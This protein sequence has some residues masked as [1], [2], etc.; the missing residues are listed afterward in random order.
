MRVLPSAAVALCGALSIVCGLAACGGGGGASPPSPDAAA[1]EDGGAP[2][3]SS[4]TAITQGP[5]AGPGSGDTG[6][7]PVDS[8]GSL[9][10]SGSPLDSGSTGD[11]A[12]DASF[13]VGPHMSLTVPNSGGPVIAHPTLVTITFAGDAERSFA[14]TLGAYL[15]TSPWLS[16]VGPQYGVGLG[17]HVPVELTQTAPGTIDD[18][19]IQALIASLILEGLAPAPMGGSAI[20][21][22][23]GTPFD[24]VDSGPPADAGPVFGADGGGDA[25]PTAE[26][27]PAVYMIYIPTTT[28][29]TIDGSGLCDVSGGGYHGQAQGSFNGLTFAYAVVSQ[30]PMTSK[31][32]LEMAV[33]HEFIE[34]ATDPA[35]SDPAWS[36]Q[37]PNNVWSYFGGEVGDLC[38][39]V[40]PQWAEGAYA[41]LQ[42]VYSNGS[43]ADGGD[44]CLPAPG[45]YF[46]ADVE[47][48][49]WVPVSAGATVTFTVQGWST[50]AVPPWGLQADKYIN[51]PSTFVPN[52]MVSTNM[53][54]NGQSATVT[55]T[56]PTG[57]ASQSYALMLVGSVASQS[58]YEYALI[59]VY[60]P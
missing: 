57:A 40:S 33:S 42:R 8:G 27:L 3:T 26:L 9:L 20:P 45:A 31:D 12:L 22:A 46:A 17:T 60:V 55:V 14:E 24:A 32:S 52:A 51:S 4:D 56:A 38:S 37:D 7:G 11:A 25:G 43:A 53:L 39:F 28:T 59:G 18:T 16:A 44:P 36:I 30:C 58:S 19:T 29:E 6:A 47:P 5:E 15:V 35:P 10:D 2:D 1:G 21:V 54:A 48:Q 23:D 50:A 34:A 49:T 13:I 41:S